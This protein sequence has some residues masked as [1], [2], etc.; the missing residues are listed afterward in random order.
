V[1]VEIIKEA[2]FAEGRVEEALREGFRKADALIL[3]KSARDG[4][5]N[6]TTAVVGFVLSRTV[7]V[8]NVGDSEAIM[9]RRQSDGS[10]KYFFPAP[11]LLSCHSASTVC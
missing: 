7:Y 6:G 4:W 3:E 10:L 5:K 8:A 2:A 9:G 11:F 1:H